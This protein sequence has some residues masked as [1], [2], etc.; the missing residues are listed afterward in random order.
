MRRTRDHQRQQG[1]SAGKD[2]GADGRDRPLRQVAQI[3]SPDGA[4]RESR[5]VLDPVGKKAPDCASLHPGYALFV[6]MAVLAWLRL[7]VGG[8]RDHHDAAIAHAALGDD[9]V[10]KVPDLAAGALQRGHFHATVI[11]EMDV[12]RRQRQIVVAVEI[13][14]QPLR[15]VPGGVIV[16]I[17][18]RGDALA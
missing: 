4:K 11:I 16:D 8:R 10:G 2:R 12:Q 15:Q 14:H 13:L 5:D 17:D 9:V 6:P 3:R 18:Q 7:L 1:R